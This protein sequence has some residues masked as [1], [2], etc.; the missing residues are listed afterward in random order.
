MSKRGTIALFGV[1]FFLV[2]WIV[3]QRVEHVYAQNEKAP[4]WIHG[5]DLKAR[6]AGQLDWDKATKYGIEV[7]RDEN[8]G[9]LVYITEKG[10]IAVV[11]G[12]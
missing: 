1:I 6:P 2:G 3:G 4:K 5:L 9:N 7:F 8:N 10:Y 12:K 11:P